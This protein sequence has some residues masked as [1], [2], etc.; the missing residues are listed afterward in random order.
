MSLGITL[1]FPVLLSGLALP[2]FCKVGQ[3]Q[4]AQFVA[5]PTTLPVIA[6]CACERGAMHH[7]PWARMRVFS[8]LSLHEEKLKKVG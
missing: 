7:A 1:P 2:S 8:F 4:A 6:T 5:C 3:P